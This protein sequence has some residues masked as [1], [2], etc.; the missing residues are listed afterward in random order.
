MNRSKLPSNNVET[1]TIVNT[2]TLKPLSGSELDTY[3]LNCLYCYYK[4]VNG[5]FMFKGKT[6]YQ[7]DGCNDWYGESLNNQINCSC[8]KLEDHLTIPTCDTDEECL[9]PY[10]IG[11]C[12]NQQNFNKCVVPG[13]QLN[14]CTTFE[15]GNDKFIYY[16]YI[17]F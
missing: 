12:S 6:A 17:C 14:K 16:N 2:S 15:F 8:G 10:C 1:P 7:L 4:D 9:K 5:C 11:I 3:V 13:I